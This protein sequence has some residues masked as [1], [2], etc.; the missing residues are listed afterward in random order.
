M[1][2]RLWLVPWIGRLLLLLFAL[3]CQAEP[4]DS[5]TVYHHGAVFTGRFDRVDADWFVVGDGR[6]LDTGAGP[7]PERWDQ[8]RRVDLAGRFVAPGFVDA[9]VHLLDG[10]LGL[11]QVDAGD[12]RDA[13]EVKGAVAR[14]AAQP[15]GAWVVVRNVGLDVLGGRF[16]THETMRDLVAPASAKP[17]L[18]LLKGG[19]H[20]YASP[21]ALE[22]LGIDRRA[23]SP[24]GGMVVRDDQGTPTGLLVDQAAWDAIR[25]L[26][27]D[28]PPETIAQAVLLAQDLAVRFGITTVGD[29]T[30]FP[31]LGAQYARMADKRLLRLRIS[32]RSFGPESM[33]RLAMKSLGARS[34]G[35]PG[36]QI[37]YFGEKYFLDSSLSTAGAAVSG[38]ERLDT[39][40]RYSVEELRDQMLFAGPFGTAFHTQSREGAERLAEA[41]T[42]ISRRRAGALPDVLDHCGRCGGGDLPRRLGAAGLR[43]TLLPG[44]LHDL[45]A[46]M[47]DL[48][49]DT[50]ASLL[51]IRELF[52]AGLEPALTSDWP[53]GAGKSYPDLPDG[54]HRLG[55]SALANVAVAVSGKAPDGEAID[56]ASTR[57]IPVGQAL[58]G[59]T[60]YGAQAIGRDD[61]GRIIPGA[62]ADFVVLPKSPFEVDPVE[63]YRMDSLATYIEGTPVGTAMPGDVATPVQA[64]AEVR[65]FSRKPSGQVLSPIFGYDPVPGFL[66]GAAYFFYPYE[67]RGLH[68]MVQ[69]YMS[70]QQVRAYGEAEVVAGRL[71][72]RLSP[73]LWVRATSLA[74][75]YYGAGMATDPDVYVKTEP[76]RLDGALGLVYALDKTTSVS[77]HARGGY[78][79]DHKASDIEALGPASE[80]H[81]D[82]TF[83][84]GRVEIAH[85]NRDNAFSTRSG[86]REALWAEVYGLQAGAASFRSL[87]GLT[88][89]R[90]VA[91]R[92]PDFVLALRAD[93]GVSAGDRNYAT[94]Y[95]IGGSDLLRGYYS[96]RF[97]G[98]HFAVGT[99]E[100]R[101]PMF[102]PISG[103]AFGDVGRVW[104]VG[105]VNPRVVAYSGGAGVRIGLPP[106]RMVRLRFDVGFAPDQ[107]G[108]FFKFNEAF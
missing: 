74:E 32:M 60:V 56:G 88:L 19:H 21:A 43:L 97:R 30:F 50:H 38:A 58:L 31:T 11:L 28:L 15:L 76:L 92:A 42:T 95:A 48:P 90:F 24:K 63:L 72:G 1:T 25:A 68:G 40:P 35:R 71:W 57:T 64:E 69:A 18:M 54:F 44:Q 98:Q 55:L 106:D 16:P 104:A 61:V 82:G 23:R 9:H 53:F 91:L 99:A 3:P 5:P 20:V 107:W 22:R 62:R 102:G 6:F 105:D 103:A 37:R 26:A 17:V 85:D 52:D 13:S 94:D 27:L 81:V 65:D 108:I 87:A 45:P 100:L 7:V 59:I 96:N 8:A 66:L 12:A 14:A 86:G 39:G 78:I 79:R 80:G 101:W 10:G 73:R 77:L 49:A 70:P 34:F 84:G 46:L 67:P 29:N 93:G 36:L 33:T 2:R 75:R 51:Q 41:R 47:R 89:T 4:T 83:A